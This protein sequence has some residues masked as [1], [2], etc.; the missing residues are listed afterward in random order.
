MSRRGR[1]LL[2]WQLGC[3]VPEKVPEKTPGAWFTKLSMTAP[4][5]RDRGV[6][7]LPGVDVVLLLA[8]GEQSISGQ[9]VEAAWDRKEPAVMGE[10]DMGEEGLLDTGGTRAA[11]DTGLQGEDAGVATLE[12]PRAA[13]AAAAAST[14]RCWSGACWAANCNCTNIM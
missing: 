12:S 3:S 2:S 9:V 14:W 11:L 13:A 1:P 4:G 5:L 7:L 6:G 8:G 10:G